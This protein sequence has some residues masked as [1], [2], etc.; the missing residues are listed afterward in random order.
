MNLEK[1][2]IK[3]D[4]PFD[5]RTISDKYDKTDRG[6]YQI[7]GTHEIYGPDTLLYIGMCWEQKFSQRL[8][9]H[10]NEWFKWLSSDASIYIGRVNKD[11]DGSAEIKI[12]KEQV[13]ELE[14]MLIYFCTPPYNSQHIYDFKPKFDLLLLNYKRKKMLPY[15]LTTEIV[16]SPLW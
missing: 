3:W 1:I 16:K 10:K 13:E 2:E 8:N 7:Y 9:Q 15:C 5:E 11:L 4:G 12:S 6:L 14:K